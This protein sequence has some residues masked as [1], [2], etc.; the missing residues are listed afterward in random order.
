VV[1]KD[2]ASE[3]FHEW[4]KRVKDLSYHLQMLNPIW[5]EQ[6]CAAASELKELSDY[7]GDDHDLVLLEQAIAAKTKQEGFENEAEALRP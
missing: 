4:R 3:N 2:P 7:L 1:L 6:I 5:P